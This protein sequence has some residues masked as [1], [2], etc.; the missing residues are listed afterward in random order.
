MAPAAA[1]ATYQGRPIHRCRSFAFFCSEPCSGFVAR[2]RIIA[3]RP[4]DDLKALDDPRGVA[5]MPSPWTSKGIGALYDF[6][7]CTAVLTG[8]TGVLG[9]EMAR[10][11]AGCHADGGRSTS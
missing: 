11:Q 1:L 6:T 2:A 5:L 4:I 10:A 3:A 9:A 8:G 7:G